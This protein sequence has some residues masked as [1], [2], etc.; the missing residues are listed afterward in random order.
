L[1]LL[2]FKSNESETASAF[3]LTYTT[4]RKYKCRLREPLARDI[5]ANS[6]VQFQLTST[7]LTNVLVNKKVHTKEN[8]DAWRIVTETGESRNLNLSDNPSDRSSYWPVYG[9]V[10]KSCN[11]FYDIYQYMLRSTS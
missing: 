11:I 1:I 6:E 7:E 3:P 10:I 4:T 5:P 2:I 8:G 9:F